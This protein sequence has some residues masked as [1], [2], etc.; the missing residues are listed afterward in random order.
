MET[1]LFI[2]GLI[3][4]FVACL[5]SLLS[6]VF[7]FPGT[8]LIAAAALIYGWL[9]GFALL[10]S[11]TVLWLF[12]LAVVAEVIEFFAATA[13]TSGS[14]PSRRVT[15]STIAGA[16]VGGIVGAPFFFGVGSLLGAL[17]GAFVGAAFAVS[18]EG[19]TVGESLRIGFAAMSGRLLGF[20]VKSAIA[21]AMIVLI[22]IAII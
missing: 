11:A 17:L 10:E 14:S 13:A 15:L 9:T 6:L 4:L 22:A 3:L 7:G 20:V 12:G 1:L 16:I 5:V 18:S 2:L 19:G 21:V 8:F